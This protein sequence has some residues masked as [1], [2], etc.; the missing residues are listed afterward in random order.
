MF[1]TESVQEVSELAASTG[2]NRPLAEKTHSGINGDLKDTSTSTSS[3][4]V[5]VRQEIPMQG[6]RLSEVKLLKTLY[7]NP[8]TDGRPVK[9][10]FTDAQS[11]FTKYTKY[12]ALERIEDSIMNSILV[13]LASINEL[14]N[15]ML[16]RHHGV[17]DDVSV[18]CRPHQASTNVY[19]W[20]K[21]KF[22]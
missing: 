18:Q 17:R 16:Y 5:G 10:F 13:V 12:D 7:E 15:C 11:T 19:T 2:T 4:V 3:S 14:I 22:V 9:V 20:C 6:P 8:K 21:I 1:R